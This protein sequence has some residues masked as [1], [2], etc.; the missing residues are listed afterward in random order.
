MSARRGLSGRVIMTQLPISKP[1][2]RE[3]VRTWN[4]WKLLKDTS[5]AD[6]KF[7]H[8]VPCRHRYGFILCYC[9]GSRFKFSQIVRAGD[10]LVLVKRCGSVD[11]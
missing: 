11:G 9:I 2:S 1:H 7:L 8:T 4:T 6:M 3:I 10:E 5:S